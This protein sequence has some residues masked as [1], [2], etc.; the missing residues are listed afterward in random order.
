MR[1]FSVLILARVSRRLCMPCSA[2]T[3]SS[4]RVFF[5]VCSLYLPTWFNALLPFTQQGTFTAKGTDYGLLTALFTDK[6]TMHNHTRELPDQGVTLL[7]AVA[8]SHQ[9][10]DEALAPVPAGLTD[11]QRAPRVS[12]ALPGAP[13]SGAESAD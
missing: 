13:C 12:H 8:S 6:R 3:I 9:S 10:P 7:F 2:A 4:S 5:I 11:A 1:I